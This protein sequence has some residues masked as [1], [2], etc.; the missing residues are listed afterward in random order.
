M[1]HFGPTLD[2]NDEE[3]MEKLSQEVIALKVWDEFNAN[4]VLLYIFLN[5]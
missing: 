3:T 2:I 4:F 5:L 1:S